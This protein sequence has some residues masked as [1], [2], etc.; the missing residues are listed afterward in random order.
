MGGGRQL[1]T[2]RAL[3]SVAVPLIATA[4]GE[5]LKDWRGACHISMWH[6]YFHHFHH[7]PPELV[8]ME[9]YALMVSRVETS[10]NI[11]K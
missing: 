3:V 9:S 2:K 7:F 6:L 10:A 8:K 1:V 4:S 5:R 11:G